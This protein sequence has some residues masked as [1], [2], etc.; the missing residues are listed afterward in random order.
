VL[1]EILLEIGVARLRGALD[2]LAGTRTYSIVALSLR[3]AYSRRI[4]AS[5]TT[6]DALTRSPY[7][8]RSM[9]SRISSSNR[10]GLRPAARSIF[11][12]FS[13]PRT[14]PVSGK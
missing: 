9:S 12:Y 10:A 13:R 6:T 7:F 5:G 3:A 14:G 8:S 11:S 1:L 2:R 4:S